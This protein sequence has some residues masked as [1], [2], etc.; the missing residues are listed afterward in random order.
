LQRGSKLIAGLGPGLRSA[1]AGVP[2]GQ[3][4]APTSRADPNELAEGPVE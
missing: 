3:F 4:R 1:G 2:F